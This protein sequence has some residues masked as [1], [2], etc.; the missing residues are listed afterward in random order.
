M[1]LAGV[2]SSTNGVSPSRFHRLGVEPKQGLMFDLD[3]GPI[4]TFDIRDKGVAWS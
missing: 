3:Y 4:N 2:G 1:E